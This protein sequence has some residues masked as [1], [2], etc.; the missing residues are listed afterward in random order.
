MKASIFCALV[1]TIGAPTISAQDPAAL[2]HANYEITLEFEGSVI[3]LCDSV[4]EF[5][6]S[7]TKLAS[8]E[9]DLN[10]FSCLLCSTRQDQR[11]YAQCHERDH[12]RLPQ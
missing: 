9:F 4:G 10:L 3:H 12:A 8:M 2:I 1:L 6:G 5:Y 11:L 7:E